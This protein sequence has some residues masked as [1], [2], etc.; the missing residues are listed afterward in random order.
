MVFP[1]SAS[2]MRPDI[3]LFSKLKGIAW[4]L[5]VDEHVFHLDIRTSYYLGFLL[6]SQT[7]ELYPWA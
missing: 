3:F 5:D 2:D 1:L 4:L 7:R 6:V